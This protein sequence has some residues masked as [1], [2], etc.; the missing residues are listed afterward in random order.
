[1]QTESIYNNFKLRIE[2]GIALLVVNR[3]D[4]MNALNEDCWKEIAHFSNLLDQRDDIKLAI[5]TGEGEK[6]FVS[7]ADINFLKKRT[8]ITA[9]QGLASSALMKFECSAKPIIAAINGYAFGGGFELAMACD[10]RIASENALFAL[11]ELGLGILPGGGGTQR[12]AKLIGLGRAK[13]M[14]FTGRRVKAEEALQY[15]IVSQVVPF[16]DLMNEAYNMA[17]IIL[18]KG[19]IS[20]RLAKKCINASLSADQEAGMLLELLSF[21]VLISSEDR[22]E[23]INAFLEKR[24][25]KFEGK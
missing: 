10:I 15:G 3:P 25:A 20:L 17:N 16:K 18:S 7:G 6:A 22:M 2:N 12:L 24:P 4:Y 21:S 9:L 1:M 5:I 14:I 19:P 23:G 8:S 11:P 13:E